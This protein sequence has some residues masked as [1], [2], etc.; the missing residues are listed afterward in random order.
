MRWHAFSRTCVQFLWRLSMGCSNTTYHPQE[1][2]R[3]RKICQGL[4]Q[5]WSWDWASSICHLL[6]SVQKDCCF[7]RKTSPRIGSSLRDCKNLLIVQS[8]VS[9]A[10]QLAPVV[11]NYQFE[12]NNDGFPSNN[13]T[14]CPRKGVSCLFSNQYFE[15]LQLIR[16]SRLSSW[17]PWHHYYPSLKVQKSYWIQHLCLLITH[18]LSILMIQNLLQGR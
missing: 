15:T 8:K 5:F 10:W 9:R 7:G 6:F 16:N 18:S 4:L 17:Q 3:H 2:A 11:R 12:A 14:I 1:R 13:W